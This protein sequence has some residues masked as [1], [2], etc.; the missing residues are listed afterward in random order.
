MING[1]QRVLI[2]SQSNDDVT[3][4]YNS[5][6]FLLHDRYRMIED[7]LRRLDWIWYFN[8]ISL[9]PI[10]HGHMTRCPF[11]IYIYTYTYNYRCVHDRTCNCIH[12]HRDGRHELAHISWLPQVAARAGV[13]GGIPPDSG[14]LQAVI[15]SIID[16][17]SR[18][19]L[20]DNP[21]N[22]LS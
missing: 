5:N 17:F 12:H 3:T 9:C 16:Q 4:C 1:W 10:G 13:P 22:Y 21:F 11:W 7:G 15:L 6:C 18:I 19:L 20:I 8:S 14:A 2:F